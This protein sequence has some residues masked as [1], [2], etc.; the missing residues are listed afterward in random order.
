M[1]KIGKAIE[2][3]KAMIPKAIEAGRQAVKSVANK[4]ANSALGRAVASVPKTLKAVAEKGIGA[5]KKAA[6]AVPKA[7][8][9]VK[10]KAEEVKDKVQAKAAEVKGKV[11]AKA[12]E[13]NTAVTNKVQEIATDLNERNKRIGDKLLK[14]LEMMASGLIRGTI[15]AGAISPLSDGGLRTSSLMLN[16]LLQ[17]RKAIVEEYPLFNLQGD[18]LKGLIDGI[19]SA[20]ARGEEIAG[21]YIYNLNVPIISDFVGGLTG[22]KDP[23]AKSNYFTV[24]GAFYRGLLVDGLFGTVEGVA[25][26]VADPFTAIEGLNNIVMN[27]RETLPA[28]G[29]GIMEYFDQMRKHGSPEDWAQLGGQAAFE[30]VS[31]IVGAGAAKTG[32]AASVS[33]KIASVSDDGARLA[34]VL[35]KTTLKSFGKNLTGS[36]D[37]LARSLDD[38]L[39]NAG[40]RAGDAIDNLRF[41]RSYLSGPGMELAG[42]GLI[43]DFGSGWSKIDDVFS[44]SKKS[45]MKN[46]GSMDNGVDI[47]QKT[48]V[49]KLKGVTNGIPEEVAKGIDDVVVPKGSGNLID[50]TGKFVDDVLENNYQK[51]VER[52][53]KSGKPIRNRSDWKEASD[54]WTTE[55][56]IA[57]GNQYNQTV[58]DADIYPYHEVNL[59]NGK[60]LDSYD[61]VSGEIISR[62]ATDLDQ[63]TES[64]FR[65]YLSEI[66]DK[67]S[68]GTVIRSDKYPQLDGLK[69]EGQYILEIPASNATISNIQ[70]YQ[71]IASEYGVILRFTEEIP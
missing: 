24:K 26:L 28:I 37:N 65:G 13:I 41:G 44:S 70:H 56:P 47:L 68:V 52:N 9:A 17:S 21:G 8:D 2:K 60:R 7:I 16:F 12:E 32:K 10:K 1:F 59:S 20:G 18:L 27:P 38:V 36:L 48:D 23:E 45:L 5:V 34:G 67:Y 55:S 54:Y 49:E 63:I 40:K 35:S 58:R 53:G 43:D 15:T 25:S 62:K 31:W 33:S 51:Y 19:K 29:S 46:S 3:A 14:E 30:V 6:A 66:G 50:D 69:L 4:V 11:Q 71:D 57:R 22:Q 42:T 64:T 61:P 39:L